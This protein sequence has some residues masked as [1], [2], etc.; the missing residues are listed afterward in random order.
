MTKCK[1]KFNNQMWLFI[2]QKASQKCLVILPKMSS[3]GQSIKLSMLYQKLF[4]KTNKQVYLCWLKMHIWWDILRVIKEG[5]PVFLS[6]EPG[7]PLLSPQR[8]L[9]CHRNITH[10]HDLYRPSVPLYRQTGDGAVCRKPL[11]ICNL[12]LI[13]FHTWPQIQ[14]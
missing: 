2:S 13:H 7:F 6:L 14:E 10:A 9:R 11:W 4:S 3:S 1:C 5:K 8:T 12:P